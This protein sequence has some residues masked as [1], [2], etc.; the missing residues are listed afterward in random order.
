MKTRLIEESQNEGGLENIEFPPNKEALTR[1]DLRFGPV[2]A[3]G[4]NAVVYSARWVPQAEPNEKN[5]MASAA[6]RNGSLA[7][8]NSIQLKLSALDISV[9]KED[10][11]SESEA[12]SG[13]GNERDVLA[14]FRPRSKS[15]TPKDKKVS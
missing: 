6:E 4:C 8:L 3:K 12:L 10:G 14:D 7:G 5:G 1:E 9:K 11:E 13:P 2:V 15:E